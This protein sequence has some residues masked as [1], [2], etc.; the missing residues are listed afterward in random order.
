MYI[1][2]ILQ[3]MSRYVIVCVS[4]KC[5]DSWQIHGIGQVWNSLEKITI[6][7]L[8]VSIQTSSVETYSQ[9]LFFVQA[10]LWIK[11]WA[12]TGA[13]TAGKRTM[14]CML[15]GSSSPHC[16]QKS[17]DAHSVD[18]KTFEPC[19]LAVRVVAATEWQLFFRM[20]RSVWPRW[21]LILD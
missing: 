11:R 18:K 16:G 6:H 10:N 7:R 2:D 9:T 12:V 8:G 19:C 20:P 21:L 13:R 5:R 3:G 14:F 15:L 17:T 4:Y 1:L